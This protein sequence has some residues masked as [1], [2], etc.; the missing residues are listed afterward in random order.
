MRTSQRGRRHGPRPNKT[1]DKPSCA[2]APYRQPLCR[3][4]T[5]LADGL[6]LK[7]PAPPTA[8]RG[9]RPNNSGPPLSDTTSE[10]RRIS[11]KLAGAQRENASVL[12]DLAANSRHF[13]ISGITNPQFAIEDVVLEDRTQPR[14][15][16]PYQAR[17]HNL[18]PARSRALCRRRRDARAASK[19]TSRVGLPPPEAP[20]D[21]ALK[22]GSVAPSA[23]SRTGSAAH[24]ALPAV[25]DHLIT[26]RSNWCLRRDPGT[27]TKQRC[28]RCC[29]P[30]TVGPGRT[31]G[32]LVCVDAA[33]RSHVS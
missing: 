12:A 22:G 7:E 5:E 1:A 25:S 8:R 15:P 26:Q 3:R 18:A 28:S 11:G 14:C 10:T 6:A 20:Q 16:A 30:A 21:R 27:V 4:P 32:W 29:P 13:L 9:I 31:G 24:R 17:N 19:G 2:F 23:D 33:R